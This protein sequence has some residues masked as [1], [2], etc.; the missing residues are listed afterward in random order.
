METDHLLGSPSL[1]LIF[2]STVLESTL[3]NHLTSVSRP[4]G[5]TNYESWIQTGDFNI[6][7]NEHGKMTEF[8]KKMILGHNDVIVCVYVY[9]FIIHTKTHSDWDMFY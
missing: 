6:I 9:V 3:R 7:R 1:F 8:L 4:L 2:D 5:P